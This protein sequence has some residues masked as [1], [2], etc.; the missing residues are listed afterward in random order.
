MSNLDGALLD[1]FTEGINA[2]AGP[3]DAF[4][5]ARVNAEGRNLEYVP[6][7]ELVVGDGSLASAL[8]PHLNGAHIVVDASQ[9]LALDPNSLPSASETVRGVIELATA[10]EANTLTDAARA[11]TPATLPT[12]GEAQ[13]GTV[14]LATAAEANALTDLTVAV[15]PGRIPVASDT[16]RGVIEIATQAECDARASATLAVTPARLPLST[17]AQRGIVELADTTEANALS[18]TALAI[19]P[20]RIP[21]AGDAQQGL[22]RIATAA[23]QETGT[24]TARAVTPGRQH[25]HKSACKAWCNNSGVVINDGYNI[26]GVTNGSTGLFT[27]SFTTSFSGGARGHVGSV[28]QSSDT[29]NMLC[30][31]RAQATG[32]QNWAVTTANTAA[33]VNPSTALATVYFGDL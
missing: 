33:L 32:S 8:A 18:S 11:V 30:A 2:P 12:S 13:R 10:A 29:H 28:V 1:E 25:F 23:E 9:N 21:L 4:K 16:Q 7:T 31:A 6:A 20:G 22:I 14:R 3:E 24:N 17:E 26:S 5:L 19:A 27:V 15:A